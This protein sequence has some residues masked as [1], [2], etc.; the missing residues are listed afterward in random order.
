MSKVVEVND[1]NFEAEVLRSDRPVLVDF[2]AAWCGPCK[3]LSPVVEDLARAYDGR[4]KVAKC[5]VDRSH[6]TTIQYGVLSVPTLLFIKDGRIHDQMLGNQPRG[7][8]ETRI[9]RL[10]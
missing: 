7:A 4:L 8:I 3:L 10:L 1:A 5:D 9:A 2:S 6:A